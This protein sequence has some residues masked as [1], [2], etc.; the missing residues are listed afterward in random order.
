M[1][2]NTLMLLI[3]FMYVAGA[4]CIDQKLN[5][6]LTKISTKDRAIINRLVKIV[7]VPPGKSPALII[8]AIE[9]YVRSRQS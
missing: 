2:P 7:K 8:N 3:G 6:R 4:G 5:I 9:E 1:N